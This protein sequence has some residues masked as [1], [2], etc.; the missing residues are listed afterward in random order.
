MNKQDLI[1]AV[2][3]TSGL[4][5]GEAS[6]AVDAVFDTIA[7]TLRKGEDVRL[8]GFG[9]FS[10]SKRKASVGR[11]PRTKEPMTINASTQAK[12]KAGKVLKDSLN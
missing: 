8:V 2:A 7:A 12:F 1:S 4:A 10:L 6:R 3:D 11:N 5:R 9:T